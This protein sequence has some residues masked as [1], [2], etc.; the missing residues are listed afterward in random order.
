MFQLIIFALKRVFPF[1]SSTFRSIK[2]L[3][4]C[5][6]QKKQKEEETPDMNKNIII[7]QLVKDIFFFAIFTALVNMRINGNV[8]VRHIYTTHKEDSV[9]RVNKYIICLYFRVL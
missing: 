2:V 1:S 7:K 4:G 6:Q 3:I 9:M 8:Y 5:S